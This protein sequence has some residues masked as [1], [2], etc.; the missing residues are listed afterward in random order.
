VV[1]CVSQEGETAEALAEA[2]PS[3]C[4]AVRADKEGG[5]KAVQALAASMPAV[6]DRAQT[7]LLY[8]EKKYKHLWDQDRDAFMRRELP[9]RFCLK[10]FPEQVS[11]QTSHHHTFHEPVHSTAWHILKHSYLNHLVPLFVDFLSAC[12]S[13]HQFSQINHAPTNVSTFMER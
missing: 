5:Q 12:I 3:F 7:L 6:V 10:S 4:E 2:K 8:W 9:D 11:A 1:K 13:L